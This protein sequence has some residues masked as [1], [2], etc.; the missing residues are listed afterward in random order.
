MSYTR[1]APVT[2]TTGPS[3]KKGKTLSSGRLIGAPRTLDSTSS[4][5]ATPAS[6][7]NNLSPNSSPPGMEG[8]T[9]QI[10]D[11]CILEEL[12]EETM[13]SCLKA[14]FSAKSIYTYAG[15]ILI[16]VNPYYFYQIYNPKYTALYQ[17]RLLDELPPH[18]F[19]IADRSYHSMLGDRQNQTVIISG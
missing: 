17:G 19:A 13:L 3:S 10:T 1:V 2:R 6:C 7:S 4:G 15:T 18:I 8:L 11:L 9:R 5:N 14:R 12:C 16:A